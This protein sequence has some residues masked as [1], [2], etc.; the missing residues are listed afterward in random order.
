MAISSSAIK[1]AFHTD[2]HVCLYA[3]MYVC[4]YVCMHACMHACMYVC[5]YL[6]M[7]VYVEAICMYACM[8]VCLSGLCKLISMYVWIYVCMHACMYVCMYVCVC[9]CMYVCVCV[10]MYSGV[11]RVHK[12]EGSLA[13]TE[14]W[15][16][17]GKSFEFFRLENRSQCLFRRTCTHALKGPGTP[18]FL[19]KEL[20][21]ERMG[22]EGGGCHA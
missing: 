9:V 8:Y 4:M 10:C 22:A 13:Y 3:C 18:V 1:R 21:R 14:L 16:S 6:G 19:P 20:E 12:R 5:M 7:Y 15:F 17:F 11:F 2:M